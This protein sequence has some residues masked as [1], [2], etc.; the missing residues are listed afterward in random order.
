M[1]AAVLSTMAALAV[2]AA[3]C[4]DPTLDRGG[5]GSGDGGDVDA[6]PGTDATGSQCTSQV[7][8][9]SDDWL[10]RGSFTG[11]D[12]VP[13]CETSQ[14]VIA[15]HGDHFAGNVPPDASQSE[16]IAA[17]TKL[18]DEAIKPLVPRL[19]SWIGYG[20]TDTC[21]GV[22]RYGVIFLYSWREVDR[23]AERIGAS[24]VDLGY[25]ERV[26]VK[27]QPL[28]CFVPALAPPAAD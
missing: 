27:L 28:D 6:N 10:A 23:A 14:V 8:G 22:G 18:F 25:S 19:K 4:D 16:R 13:G 24:L 26:G 12:V 21:L 1:R 20:V 5:G 9:T 2:A 3:A 11:Y 17:L 15:A 7:V